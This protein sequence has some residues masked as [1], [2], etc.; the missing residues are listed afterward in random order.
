[1]LIID[2][3]AP[4]KDSMLQKK[5][6]FSLKKL[7]VQF[8]LIAI[9]IPTLVLMG[10]GLFQVKAQSV[11]LENSLNAKLK[12]EAAQLSAS[13][14]TALFNFDDETCRVIVEAAMKKPEIT[15]IR[16]WDL[17]QVYLTSGT[18][19]EIPGSRPEHPKLSGKPLPSRTRSSAGWR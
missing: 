8:S 3:L 1:M 15:S 10:V 9:G 5:T 14:S 13:L 11:K 12:N 19:G 4:D 6:G 17:N 16:V 2:V 18:D 7:S